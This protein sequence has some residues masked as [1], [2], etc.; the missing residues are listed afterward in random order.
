MKLTN[1]ITYLFVFATLSFLGACSDSR[2]VTNATSDVNVQSIGEFCTQGPLSSSVSLWQVKNFLVSNLN[3]TICE[4]GSVNLDSDGDGVCDSDERARGLNPEKRFSR[5]GGYSDYFIVHAMIYSEVLPPCTDRSDADHD[6]LTTC[7]EAYMYNQN[8]IGPTDT[9]SISSYGDPRNPDTDLDGFLDGIEI[10]SFRNLTAA[11]NAKDVGTSYDGEGEAGLQI[12]KHKNPLKLDPS[13][14]EYDTR[15]SP[16][17]EQTTSGQTCYSFTQ[18]RLLLYETLQ[19]KAEDNFPEMVHEKGENIV[20]AYF[21][22]I[23]STKPYDHGILKYSLQKLKRRSQSS[24]DSMG[25][26]AGMKINDTVFKSYV[27]P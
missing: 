23:P 24:S 3:S 6:F 15:I 25:F 21:M 16:L 12:K 13:S 7:E 26:E 22:Q 11:T 17:D 27:V 19:V 4:D 1:K 18:S 14:Y 8:P 9:I 5:A 20:F 10:F 2:L